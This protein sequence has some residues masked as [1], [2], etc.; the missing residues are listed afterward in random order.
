MKR[1][2][3][4]IAGAVAGV[5][6]MGA[7]LY[8]I[9]LLWPGLAG[10]WAAPTA[11]AAAAATESARPTGTLPPAETAAANSPSATTEEPPFLRELVR[12]AT[13]TAAAPAAPRTGGASWLPVTRPALQKPYEAQGFD[14]QRA[15]LGD[16]RDRWV[17]ASP[18]GLALVEI[19][20]VEAVEEAS[21]SVFGPI[22]R[23]AE[24]GAKRAIYMLLMMNAVLPGWS[25]GAEW[26]SG[27]LVNAERQSGDYASEITH[28][29]VRVEF[30]F[31]AQLGA[32]T[33]SFKPD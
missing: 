21:V 12:T 25:E 5:L 18:D 2:T 8:T 4:L 26:F 10:R 31:D 14:F 13:P 29:G 20:G 11:T 28:D 24:E 15:Q 6:V 17:A 27:E 30:S 23:D 32:I 19:V 1:L 7:C 3:G 33:L 22:R 9:A 16:N